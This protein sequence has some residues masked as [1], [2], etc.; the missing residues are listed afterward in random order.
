MKVEMKVGCSE[1]STVAQLVNLL[2]IKMVV[3]KVARWVGVMV[4][5]LELQQ[6]AK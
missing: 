5:Y 4:G 6:V 2:E 3:Q 1:Q